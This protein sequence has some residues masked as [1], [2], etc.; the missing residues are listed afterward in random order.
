MVKCEIILVMAAII[1]VIHCDLT[2]SRQ[3]HGDNYT[4]HDEIAI[5]SAQ[6]EQITNAVNACKNFGS[7]PLMTEFTIL[8]GKDADK[9]KSPHFAALDHAS[10][11]ND[12]EIRYDCGEILISQLL[13][14]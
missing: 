13:I 10:R 3:N 5:N 6:S 2:N 12:T 1:C 11:Y 4:V 7:R 9:R 8:G 14:V